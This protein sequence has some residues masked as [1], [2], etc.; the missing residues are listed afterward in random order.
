MSPEGMSW[1]ARYQ[2]VQL[3][4]RQ[5]GAEDFQIEVGDGTL[6]YFHPAKDC[7]FHAAGLR[8]YDHAVRFAGLRSQHREDPANPV[9]ILEWELV[10]SG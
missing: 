3:V 5:R 7:D 4:L 1:R 2:N 8:A 10:E 6:T 9:R